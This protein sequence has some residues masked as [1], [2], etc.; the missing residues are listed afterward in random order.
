MDQLTQINLSCL[1]LQIISL[2][3]ICEG[4]GHR[5]TERALDGTQ[6]ETRPSKWNWPD[7][8][9]PPNTFWKTWRKTFEEQFL[10]TIP[11]T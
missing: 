9:R 5:I 3:D 8:P 2:A 1:D 4:D 11:A 7:V 10:I 6:D